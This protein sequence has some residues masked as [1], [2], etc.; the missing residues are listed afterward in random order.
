MDEK[1]DESGARVYG[2]ADGKDQPPPAP[3]G[4]RGA[5][6]TL[7]P[8]HGN[9]ALRRHVALDSGRMVELVEDSGVGWA[10]AEGRAGRAAAAPDAA[11]QVAPAPPPRQGPPLWWI[12]VALA[13]GA[14]LGA[15]LRRRRAPLRR[16][17]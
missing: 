9:P 4:L 1:K 3:Q 8:T 15:L 2:M 7:D 10:E 13:G 16:R 6:A 14:A 11:F 17:A 12:G 5:R